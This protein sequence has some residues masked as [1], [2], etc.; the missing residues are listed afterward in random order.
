M[1]KRAAS[2]L[3]M[4]VLIGTMLT[5]CGGLDKGKAPKEPSAKDSADTQGRS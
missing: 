3:L 4:G 1:F 5:G 2:T